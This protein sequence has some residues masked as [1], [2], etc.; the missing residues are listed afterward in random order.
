MRSTRPAPGT[1]YARVH[2]LVAVWLGC[3]VCWG[4]GT[5]ARAQAQ[6]ELERALT[7]TREL[8]GCVT[9]AALRAR[10]A[11]YLSRPPQLSWLTI[12]VDLQVPQFRVLRAGAV[13]AERRF[14]RAPTDCA[15][16][17]DVLA[18]AVAIAIEQVVEEQTKAP[19]L[20]AVSGEPAAV[21][22]S[23]VTTGNADPRSASGAASGQGSAARAQDRSAP[24]T[25]DA[26]SAADKPDNAAEEA[27]KPADDKSGR[28]RKVA[29]AERTPARLVSAEPPPS[30]AD[31]SAGTPPELASDDLLR[32]PVSLLGAG[33]VLF[34]ALP[35]AAP[36][37]SV[38]AE[39]ALVPAFRIGLSGLFS[40]PV[41]SSFQGG[42]VST[43][44]YG[45]QLTGCLNT[46][47]SAS[48]LLHGCAGAVGGVIDARG[49]N[50][51]R[52]LSARMGWIAGLVRAR[53]EFPVNGRVAAGVYADGRVN[54][55]RP[56]LQARLPSEPTR[57]RA[58]G[59][60]G[61]A[62]GVELIVRLQ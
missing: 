29:D 40:L 22:S 51:A 55:L 26:E 38:G 19:A 33:A 7:V 34:E 31:R 27:Q 61:A 3:M 59:L 54:L 32:R 18:L 44:L 62:L 12:E 35:T 48:L 16:R 45:A 10:T 9:A 21:A 37:F 11:Q 15:E 43:Q 30:A 28:A 13:L 56:E 4:A 14:E 24:A 8:P 47:I 58:V 46:A 39:L 23:Q 6:A 53:L 36:A 50:F 25:Q 52:S 49:E 60:L 1:A 20:A 17:R 41:S 57:T 5:V 42:T 2:Q